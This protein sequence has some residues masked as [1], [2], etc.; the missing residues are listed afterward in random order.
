ML[1]EHIQSRQYLG[2]VGD[3]ED[4]NISVKLIVDAFDSIFTGTYRLQN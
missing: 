4:F 1:T 3:E 2:G